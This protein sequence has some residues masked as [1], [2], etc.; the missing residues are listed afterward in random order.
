MSKP[1]PFWGSK[2]VWKL[3][4][5]ERKVCFVANVQDREAE[6]WILALTPPLTSHVIQSKLL[7]LYVWC[8]LQCSNENGDS[9][10]HEA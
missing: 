8:L 3:Y 7:P 5:A 10:P 1:S 9:L 4:S 6:I 2:E